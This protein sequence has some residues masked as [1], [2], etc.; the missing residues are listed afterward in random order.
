M[1]REIEALF[2]AARVFDRIRGR[3]IRNPKSSG[4]ISREGVESE[5]NGD[6]KWN[7]EF[8]KKNSAD[9]TVSLL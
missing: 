1:E 9:K 4:T 7:S 5:R 3:P 8:S 6:D 2:I